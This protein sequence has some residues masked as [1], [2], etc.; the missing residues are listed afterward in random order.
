MDSR[1]KFT[2]SPTNENISAATNRAMSLATGEIVALLDHDDLLHPAALG[3]IALCYSNNPNV[4][5]VYSDDDKINLENKRY[6]PQ[7][8]PGWSPILLLSFMYMSHLFTF[9]RNL[10]DKVGGFRLGFE[11]CQDF[12]LALRMSEIARTVERIP[13][14]L[15][16]WRAAEGSTALSADTKP[17]AFA[18]GQRAVQEAFDRR[19]IKAKVAQPSFA[20]AAR[21]GIFEPI[22]PDDGPKVT[23]IIP[24]RDK[25][26][27]LRRCVD[28]IRLT[29]YKNYDILIV[30][31]ESS[32][33]ETLTYLANCDAEILRIASPE[34][35]FSFSHLINAGVAAAAGEYVLLLN[36]DTEVISPGWLSQMVGYAQMEQVGAVGARLMYEDSRLQHGGITHGLHEGMAGHSFKLLAN[37]DHGYMSLAKVSRETAGVTAAC[38]LTPRH[39]FIRMGGLDANNFNVAYNDVDYCYRLVDAGYFCVQ[40]ASA[41]LYHYE[42][43]TRG[44]SDN[45]LEELAMRKKYSARVDKWYN[46]NLSLKNEQFE[47]A[48][49]HLHV[50][51]DETPRVLFVSH[52]LNHEGAPNSLF[53][54]SNGLKTIQAVDPVVISPYDGPLKDRYGAAGIPVH[55]TRTPLTDW[56]AE[57]AWNAEI[58]R[59]AQSFLYAGIQ[60]VVANTA[61]SFW[62]VEVARVANLPC[63]WIIRE[64]EPWQTYFSHF[65]THISNAAYNAFDYPYKTVF[66]ARSTMDAWRP[67]DSRHSFSLI[68]NGLDTE[69]L[70]QSFEG[71]D[72]NKCR[73]MMGV[74]DDVCVF[75]CVGT[76]SSRKGQI[77]LIEAYTAL[78]PELARRAAIFLVGDRPGDYSSQLHNIIRDLPEELSS[79]IHVIPETPAAR[80]YLVGSDVFVCSSRVESY[81]RVTLEAMAAGLPLISTGVWGIREQV[82]KDYN[83]FLYEPGDTG[84]LATHM[85]NM[86]NEPEMRT[87]FASRSKP[88]FQSLPDF[89]FMR[90]SYRVIISEA[91]GTR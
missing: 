79:R 72:R 30:D 71:L 34:T 49:H 77:D 8:K 21:L 75:T 14:V 31:N 38:M 81:P 32:E 67:L 11:G 27:L 73:E 17:E 85:K 26:E 62:A 70:V 28:S 74:A 78:N 45:P 24:T 15:Y 65:P 35:G 37:Y 57:E 25:V 56:P 23:I 20:K 19:G 87:L 69:K 44:F 40:C 1:I 13:Q 2:T 9:R 76:I 91:V 80:S 82:R 5:I 4:D 58:K 52:N 46:P 3:E 54:L 53:E 22:F 36:N 84:A 7:F 39:L 86:I 83:A 50:P 48:R 43:K 89:A 88:V 55:I 18:R 41:E 6:A 42:G 90:D 63:I 59:M 66:V 64:S 51:S 60:V 61:D 12:D 10:F 47:V 33:P 16:H 29:K 68:R